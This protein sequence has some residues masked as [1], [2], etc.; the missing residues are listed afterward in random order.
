MADAKTMTN[1]DRAKKAAEERW[2]PTIPKATHSGILIIAGKEI[3]CDVLEDGRRVLRHQTF[4]KVMGKSK[5]GSEEVERARMLK[6]PVFVTANNLTPYLTKV[7][8]ERG[9]EIFYKGIDGRK[10]IGYDAT[11][12]PETCK[13]YV[14]AENDG[15][16]QKKQI[17]IAQICKTILYGLATV[18]ITA[19]IDDCTGFV[20][21]RERNE[22]QKILD[23]YIA[24]E[25][26]EWTRKFP[27]EFFKQTYRIHG[28]DYPKIR[29]HPQYLG[30]FINKYIYDKLPSGVLKELQ[31]KN[32]TNGNG[33]RKYKHHQFLTED[34]GDDNLKKQIVQVITVMKLSENIEEFKK[35]IDRL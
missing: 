7:L 9:E 10:L 24:Q 31:K 21:V 19:L 5:P 33:C 12:L 1:T 6:I 25:L 3:A 32:P 18:G 27:N 14:Q 26:R 13:I 35:M 16:L 15:V 8:T 29:N 34:I 23:K 28:W 30:K 22:L 20:E 11:L 4:A 17:T 2:N